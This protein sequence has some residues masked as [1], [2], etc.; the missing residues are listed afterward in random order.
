LES[1]EHFDKAC[2]LRGAPFATLLL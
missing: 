1:K 2:V